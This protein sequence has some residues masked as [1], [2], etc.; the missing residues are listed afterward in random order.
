ML[1]HLALFCLSLGVIAPWTHS[2]VDSGRRDSLVCPLQ[3]AEDREHSLALD[4]DH[5]G[6]PL[7]SMIF[8]RL[9]ERAPQA[10][11]ARPSSFLTASHST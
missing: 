10:S 9:V 1:L 8:L 7:G 2:L 11:Q 6:L 4:F 3:G 5:L